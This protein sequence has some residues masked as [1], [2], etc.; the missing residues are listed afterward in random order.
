MADNV[1]ENKQDETPQE[2]VVEGDTKETVAEKAPAPIKLFPDNVEGMDPEE[3]LLL[4]QELQSLGTLMS[5]TWN[6]PIYVGKN[7]KNPEIQRSIPLNIFSD[8]HLLIMKK[9]TDE[10]LKKL[11]WIK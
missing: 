5:A 2:I 9:R 7:T 4:L 11:Q 3:R 10:V 1:E 6:K 8:Q